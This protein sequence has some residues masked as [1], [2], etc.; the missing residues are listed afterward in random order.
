MVRHELTLKLPRRRRHNRTLPHPT[1]LKHK[2]NDHQRID[3]T[4]Y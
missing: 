4:L 2:Y 1:K 3:K